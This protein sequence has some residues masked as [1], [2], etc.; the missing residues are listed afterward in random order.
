MLTITK[1]SQLKARDHGAFLLALI[2]SL[3]LFIVDEQTKLMGQIRF[4]LSTLVNPIEQ[5]ARLPDSWANQHGQHVKDMASLRLEVERLRNQVLLLNYEKQQ[6]T[7]LLQENERLKMLLGV[8][9]QVTKGR[10]MVSSV[11]DYNPNPFK[12]M[13]RLNKGSR[14][15]ISAGLPVLDAHGMMGQLISVN[16]FESDLLLISDIDTQ[17]P[18]SIQRT[19]ARGILQG[20]GNQNE[21]NIKFLPVATNVRVGDLL[22]T[23]GL[24]GH[25]PAGLALA[26][27]TQ[28]TEQPG[29]IFWQVTAEPLAKITTSREVLVVFPTQ[30]TTTHPVEEKRDMAAEAEVTP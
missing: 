21:L 23:S 22:E 12:Q 24:D 5:L 28:V 3:T 25:F 15:G 8:S 13:L 16:Y 4:V 2:F 11:V 1:N 10:L 17:I 20:T 14:D 26:K 18:I 27:I 19:G 6:Q 30:T 9:S 7:Q 29:A